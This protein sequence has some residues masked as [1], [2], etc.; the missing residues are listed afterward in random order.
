MAVLS[1]WAVETK[2]DLEQLDLGQQWVLFAALEVVAFLDTVGPLKRMVGYFLAHSGMGLTS[3]VV[4]AVVGVSDRAVRKTRSQ[5]PEDR[6]HN[7]RHPSQGHR[8][9]K[10]ATRDVGRLAKFFATNPKAKVAEVLSFVSI[11]F[12]V[13]LD[14]LTLRRFVKKFGLGCLRGDQVIVEDSP[15]LSPTRTSEVHSC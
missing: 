6:L 9:P 14:R 5:S 4:A 13:D 3:A 8:K 1:A 7:V 10:L 11:E 2:I 15:L 12:S